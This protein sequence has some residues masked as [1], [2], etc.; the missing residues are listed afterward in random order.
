VSA[1][2]RAAWRLGEGVVVG[3]DTGGTQ[4]SINVGT[5]WAGLLELAECESPPN[6]PGWDD[7][8]VTAQLGGAVGVHWVLE[9]DANASAMAEWAFGAGRG[10]TD[11]IYL[12]CG[13]GLGAGMILDGAPYRG[14]GDLAGEVGHWRLGPDIGPVHYG[15]RGSFEGYCSGA[16]IVEWY[17]YLGGR[18]EPDEALSAGVIA[19]R[20]RRGEELARRVFD[21][22]AHQLGKGIALLVDALA[23][24]VVVVGGIYGYATDLLRPGMCSALIAA[25]HPRLVRGAKVVPALL[26][27]EGR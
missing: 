1:E 2:L 27:R 12:T 21:Q 6:L 25:S 11:L 24:A 9:N 22:S 18:V 26:G 23:P 17:E 5:Y 20:A 3:V 16:G 10:V 15:K 19:H 14:V 13:M 7:V 8:H 4:C